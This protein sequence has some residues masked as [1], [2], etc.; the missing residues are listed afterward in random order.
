M[1]QLRTKFFSN[2]LWPGSSSQLSSRPVFKYPILLLGW[3]LSFDNN[4]LGITPS[5]F[6]IDPLSFFVCC[7]LGQTYCDL[8]F[9]I[10]LLSFINSLLSR[11]E[12]HNINSS[13]SSAWP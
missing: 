10:Y 1:G 8:S 4:I 7:W 11:C 12:S 2:R 3:R 6:L 13:L 9:V 5:L